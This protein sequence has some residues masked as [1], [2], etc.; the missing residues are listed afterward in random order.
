MGISHHL[1]KFMNMQRPSR[2]N[3]TPK[4][5]VY[6]AVVFLR[7]NFPCG[8]LLT[9]GLVVSFIAEYLCL[10]WRSGFT[11]FGDEADDEVTFS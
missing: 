5:N 9:F 4:W 3:L 11:L 1:I 8:N 10:V 7:I 6:I 2:G